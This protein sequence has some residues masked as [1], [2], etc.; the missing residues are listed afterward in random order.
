M[1]DDVDD[2]LRRTMAT[3]DRQVPPEYFDALPARTLA[4]LDDPTIA[5]APLVA[6]GDDAP[7]EPGSFAGAVPTPLVP[8]ARSRRGA[9]LAVAG[10]GLAAAAGVLIFVSIGDRDRST[11]AA[12]QLALPRA[13]HYSQEKPA[14]AN[15]QAVS[16]KQDD[17]VQ[18]TPPEVPVKSAGDERGVEKPV[19]KAHA[20]KLTVGKKGGLETSSK[21]A[22]AQK[23]KRGPDET[24]SPDDVKRR[25]EAIAAEVRACGAG[26]RGTAALRLTVEPSGRASGVA[27]TGAFAGTPV[28]ACVER[29][30]ASL[31][32][33]V[34][35]GAPQTF[36]YSYVFS[37]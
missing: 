16:A 37:E 9:I 6:L 35:D 34:R 8:R 4:R 22:K 17:A 25:M 14:V 11:G 23:T 12:E 3:L 30:V 7:R 13:Q 33:P 27:V 19:S 21:D 24:L 31:R 10:L 28:A 20:T 15:E 36:E 5:D 1:S 32:F 2:L 29:A 18:R 26:A